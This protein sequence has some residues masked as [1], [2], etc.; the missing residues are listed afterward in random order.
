[1]EVEAKFR[2]PDE[3]TFDN[4]LEARTL[5]GYRVGPSKTKQVHDRYLDTA[6]FA[7]LRGG[8][9]CRVRLSQNSRLITL[10]SVNP[11]QGAI[12][13]REELELSLPPDGTLEIESWPDSELTALARALS[14]GKPL[15]LLFELWQERQVRLV[16][17]A[18]D[19]RPVIEFSLDQVRLTET[20]D[21]E[22]FELEMELLPGGRMGDLQVLTEAL[23]N[24]WKLTGESR[25]KFERGLAAA[26]PDVL[27][28]L[29]T[30]RNQ[31]TAAACQGNQ[32]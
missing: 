24:D 4:L 1:M 31:Q 17:T 2:V 26:R 3:H 30:L 10:K 25:S 5:A 13:N 23:L 27:R 28:L 21:A 11:A 29:S 22:I 32:L 15:E 19:G 8:F 12:H 7:F 14:A 18:A 9:A 16:E 20:K 6:D